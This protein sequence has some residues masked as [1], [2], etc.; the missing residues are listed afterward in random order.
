MLGEHNVEV[1]RDELGYDNEQ[2]SELESQK[3]LK[4]ERV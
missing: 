3:I 2:I 1:L 4:Q